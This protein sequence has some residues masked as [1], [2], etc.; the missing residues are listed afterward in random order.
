[1]I[2]RWLMQ[3]FSAVAVFVCPSDKGIIFSERLCWLVV[4]VSLP[5]SSLLWLLTISTGILAYMSQCCLN[6]GP[7]IFLVMWITEYEVVLK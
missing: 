5:E 4:S 2:Q 1:M 6:I 7:S 3:E